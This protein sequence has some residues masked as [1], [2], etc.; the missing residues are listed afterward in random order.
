MYPLNIEQTIFINKDKVKTG[1][2]FESGQRIKGQVS[3]FFGKSFDSYE[4]QKS[5]T[6]DKDIESENS[7]GTA[8]A[9]I[10]IV[11]AVILLL[12]IIIYFIRKNKK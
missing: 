7:D 2:S 9:F 3:S 8:G 4:L 1:D 11:G 6:D 12:F 5:T 10:V